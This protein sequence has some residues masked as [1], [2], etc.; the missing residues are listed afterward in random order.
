MKIILLILLLIP[1]LFFQ[2]F[3]ITDVINNLKINKS[4]RKSTVLS[5]NI[6]TH[7]Y[8]TKRLQ[9]NNFRVVR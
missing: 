2:G 7:S 8:R 9:R 5:N 1:I 3:I 4:R 6:D